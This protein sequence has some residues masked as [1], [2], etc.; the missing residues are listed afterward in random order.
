MRRLAL[1]L[2]LIATACPSETTPS[3]ND[4]EPGTSSGGMTTEAMTNADSSSSG[5]GETSSSETSEDPTLDPGTESS[6]TDPT[7]AAESTTDEPP[8]VCGDGI[9]S[10]NEAC[11]GSVFAD[12]TCQSQGFMEG[13]LTCSQD[14][15]GFS[16]VNCFI[17]GDGE[18]QGT[19]ECDG[20]LDNDVACD[21]LGFTE[22]PV[23]CDMSTCQIDISQCTLCG[24]G[25]AEGDEFC[26]IDDLFGEDCA[27]LGF[28][29]GSLACNSDTCGYDYTLCSGGQ[30]IQD[31]EVGDIPPEFAFSDTSWVIN[32]TAPINGSYDA[33]NGDIG[34]NGISTMSL[35]VVFSIDGTV[36]F[37]HH[38][39][40]EGCCDFLEFYIDGSLQDEWSGTNAA[41]NASY[42]ITAG[43]HTLEWR[44]TK[45]FSISTGQDSVWIDD[46]ALFG[47]VPTG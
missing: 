13:T 2:C 28:D 25:V 37:M 18:I 20:P 45:D 11:D 40:T 39:E 15:L 44:Y 19:E 3:G 23:S 32:S 33:R 29:G 16:T 9:I 38:E 17:C 21:T 8:A 43:N 7:N 46:L 31:F 26:D 12:D 5:P 10:G 24:D 6:S 14:C 41:V 42:N 22:G 34:D 35:D 4:T 36:D 27:S 30:Y 47:G 1:P